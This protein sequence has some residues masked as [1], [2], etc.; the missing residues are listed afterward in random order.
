[1]T[2]DG[3]YNWN[4]IEMW[5]RGNYVV[6]IWLSVQIPKNLVLDLKSIPLLR[7]FILSLL[8]WTW[9]NWFL[10][11]FF[12]SSIKMYL[13]WFILFLT[14]LL[15]NLLGTYDTILNFLTFI[16][17]LTI[18]LISMIFFFPQIEVEI[19]LNRIM[20][21]YIKSQYGASPCHSWGLNAIGLFSQTQCSSY[22]SSWV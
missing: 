15:K 4:F 1:M 8:V 3:A 17:D 10:F 13:V 18:I 19:L 5:I 22:V 9:K 21:N 2:N 11:S 6:I 7:S 12:P 16:R 20:K 14:S